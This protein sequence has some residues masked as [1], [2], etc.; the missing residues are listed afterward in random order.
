M[1]KN[2][3]FQSFSFISG[4]LQLLGKTIK[5]LTD[6]LFHVFSPAKNFRCYYF[7]SIPNNSLESENGAKIRPKR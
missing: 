2:D 1:L 4:A 6:L 5:I 3:N 7:I